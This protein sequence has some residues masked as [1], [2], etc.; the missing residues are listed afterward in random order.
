MDYKVVTILFSLL[1]IWGCTTENQHDTDP[2]KETRTARPNFE[3]IATENVFVYECADSLQITAHVTKDST[4]LFLPD[5]S[6]KVD[7]VRSGSG[8][9][10]EADSYLY[11][12]KDDEAL[13]QLPQG[14]LMSCQQIPQEKSWQ[15]A[16]LRGV[17]F[18]ALGQEPGWHLDISKGDQITYIGNYGEDTI[19]ASTPAPSID[20]KDGRTTYKVQTDADTL[21]VEITEEPCTDPMSGF[22]F[23]Q[24]VVVTAG[25]QNYSGCGRT[26][27]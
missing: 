2:K 23:P 22:S 17:D 25:S 5:T 20:S 8:A 4:W 27:H 16:K 24:T 1:L 26:L 21:I 19:S 15:A 18:R 10:Y 13:L 14:S 7:P 12:S 9:R 3:S 11:W 6:L